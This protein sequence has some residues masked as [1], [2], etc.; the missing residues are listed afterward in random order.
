MLSLFVFITGFIQHGVIYNHS[1][2]AGVSILWLNTGTSEGDTHILFVILHNAV[3]EGRHA[4]YS[5]I[6]VKL[7][8]KSRNIALPYGAADNAE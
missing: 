5:V 3:A 7:K 4:V 6:T 8:A 2:R 1:G